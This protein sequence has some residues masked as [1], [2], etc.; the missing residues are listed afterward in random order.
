MHAKNIKNLQRNGK[1]QYITSSLPEANGK[2]SSSLNSFNPFTELS[3]VSRRPN[4]CGIAE[5][6]L[7]QRKIECTSDVDVC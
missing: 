2:A 3:V 1:F 4:L 7:H 6:R 5:L